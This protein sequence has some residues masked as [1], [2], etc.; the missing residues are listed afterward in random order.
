[1]VQKWLLSSISEV[2]A[3]KEQTGLNRQVDAQAGQATEMEFA[4][5]SASSRRDRGRASVQQEVAAAKAE[6]EWHS[7]IASLEQ[8]LLQTIP[9]STS[10]TNNFHPSSPQGLVLAGPVPV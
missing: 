3:Q 6:R 1:M 9:T 2:L 8:L 5:Q 4:Q 10:D 7:A